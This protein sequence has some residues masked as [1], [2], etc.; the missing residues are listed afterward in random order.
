MHLGLL[1]IGKPRSFL[2]LQGAMTAFSVPTAGMGNSRAA[3][4]VELFAIDEW[5]WRELHF[6]TAGGI[7]FSCD[8]SRYSREFRCTSQAR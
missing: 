6:E 4:A 3:A 5:Q 7:R 1:D 2:Q 8:C